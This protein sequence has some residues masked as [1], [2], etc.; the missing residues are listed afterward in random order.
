MG[1]CAWA[2]LSTFAL[3]RAGEHLREV[4]AV[5]PEDGVA[6]LRQAGLRAVLGNDAHLRPQGIPL[7]HEPQCLLQ[8]TS[9]VNGCYGLRRRKA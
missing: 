8:P 6:A 3:T 2:L 5:V 9:V 7:A 1:G 4:D